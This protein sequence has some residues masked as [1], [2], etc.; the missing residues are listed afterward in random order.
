MG[1]RLLKASELPNGE[2]IGDDYGGIPSCVIFVDLA[3]GEG[4]KLHKHP[5]AE[6]FFV[7]EGQATF[8]DGASENILTAGDVAIA[9]PDQPHGFTNSGAGRLRQID[10]HLSSTFET[11][12]LE[13]QQT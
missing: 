5:Y 12:W 10:V 13:D 11:E 8:R 7:V 2:L 3:P 1:I 9:P 6:L 4:P